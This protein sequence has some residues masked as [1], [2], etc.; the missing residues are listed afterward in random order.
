MAAKSTWATTRRSRYHRQKGM[1]KATTPGLSRLPRSVLDLTAG[2]VGFSV[3]P[4]KN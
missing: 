2:I 1:R 3:Q 4:F